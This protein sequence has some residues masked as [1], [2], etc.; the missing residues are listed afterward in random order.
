MIIKPTFLYIGPDKS[1][2]T[3][4]YNILLQHPECFVPSIKDIYF[5]DKHYEKG[6]EWYLSF[7]KSAPSNVK[8]IG[9]LSHDYLFSTVA[10]ENIYA[11][12]ANIKLFTCLRNPVDR[13]FSQYLFMLRSGMTR[14]CFEDALEEFPSL[15][16]NSMYF[17][18]LSNYYR[19]FDP[20]Q[21]KILFFDKLIEN[22]IFFAKDIFQFLCI[23]YCDN[24]D[25]RKQV[26]P[27]SRSRSQ[28]L[29]KLAKFSA[30]KLR[31]AG[32]LNILGKLKNSKINQLLYKKYEINEKP[33]MDKNIRLKLIAMYESDIV[34]LS[35]F[36]K[37]DLSHW[38]V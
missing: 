30:N 18:H 24:I 12:F 16:S 7:Y 3:W 6:I 14:L 8:A 38:L 37:K 25:Y 33:C 21:I 22:P 32:Y 15:I 34:S 13:T 27:A 5:F 23:D 19:I 10:A 35:L 26:L 29:A 20:N 11:N 28:I 36:L 17:N 4:I 1:G 31:N 2:S 9:E